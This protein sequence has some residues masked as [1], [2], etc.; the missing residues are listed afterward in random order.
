MISGYTLSIRCG[1]GICI[2]NL[3]MASR[4]A[5]GSRYGQDLWDHCGLY[6]ALCLYQ[7][8]ES[9]PGPVGKAG[10][11][12][13]SIRKVA[14]AGRRLL[15]GQFI[16]EAFLTAC[17]GRGYCLMG[18]RPR[19]VAVLYV[20]RAAAGPS[21]WERVVLGERRGIYR[22][23]ESACGQLSCLLSFG[24]QAGGHLSQAI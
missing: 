16:A 3:T 19:T 22:T 21:F 15:I 13:K 1:C 23:D 12:G 7:F 14:G 2:A 4:W 18:G 6:P 9:E 20:D 5:G 11:R 17:I 8:Y 24:V 10:K